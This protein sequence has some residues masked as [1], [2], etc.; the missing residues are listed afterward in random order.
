MNLWI[1]GQSSCL[2]HGL[3]DPNLSWINQLSRL[4]GV[5]SVYNLAQTGVDNLYIYHTIISKLD[6]ISSDDIVITG[7]SHP[8]RKCFIVDPDNPIIHES[9]VYPG[10]PLFI[11]SRGPKKGDTKEKWS[12]MIP[13]DQGV[14]YFDIWFR[15]YYSDI[16]SRLNFQS[17]IDSVHLKLPCRYIPFWFSKESV[18]GISV[19]G[20]FWLD[21]IIE[22][23]CWIS[24]FDPHPNQDG[25]DKMTK[26]FL[27]LLTPL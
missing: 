8:S 24:D 6:L 22:N 11:R 17:Y 14:P 12:S 26:I 23:Q 4:V 2:P 7:W 21:F 20:F 1:F 18:D 5:D 19:T 3:K 16:E 9:L 15:D 27:N 10:Q 25:H 13:S